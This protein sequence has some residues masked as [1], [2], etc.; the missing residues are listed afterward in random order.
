MRTI[1]P[2][3]RPTL[4]DNW[5]RLPRT[6]IIVLVILGSSLVPAGGSGEERAKE[7]L[8]GLRSRQLYDEA[9]EFL[10]ESQANDLVSDDFREVIEF[11]RGITRLEASRAERDSSA[12]AELLD[13]ATDS[14]R[15][16][17]DEHKDHPLVLRAREKL[18]STLIERG[19]HVLQQAKQAAAER[20][21]LTGEARQLY[22][23]SLE[24]FQVLEKQVADELTKIPRVLDAIKDRDAVS[25]RTQLRATY[26]QTQLL[27]GAVREELADAW[28]PS[29]KEYREELTAAAK[30][31]GEIYRKYRT[32]LAGLY[33]HMYQG[34]C[35]QKL[36]DFDAALKN[37]DDILQ[38]PDDQIAFRD[39]QTRTLI[40]ALECWI[41]PA[42]KQYAKAVSQGEAWLE[43]LPEEEADQRDAKQIR[44][45]VDKARQLKK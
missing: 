30:Q 42:Q 3:S 4:T 18:G 34:R 12:R 28:T 11:E 13:K 16:F 40:L 10:D 1:A 20:A 17:I 25:K 5:P 27:I 23:E 2:C 22:R 33:A 32:R 37:Y 41:D 15:K 36:G 31:Y 8:E 14:F 7:F 45:L 43:K 24:Q 9:L 35:K 6:L 19:R 26:L 38:Q 44:E 21:A 39:L 29:D